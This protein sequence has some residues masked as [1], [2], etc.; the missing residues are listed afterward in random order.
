MRSAFLIDRPVF[1]S[2]GAR[3]GLVKAVAEH[4]FEVVGAARGQPTYWFC[5]DEIVSPL[6]QDSVTICFDAD[7]LQEHKAGH[8]GD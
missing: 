5:I 8:E 2:D 1:T 7:Q 3:I 6:Q 4:Y